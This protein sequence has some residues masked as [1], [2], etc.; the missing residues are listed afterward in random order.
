MCMTMLKPY[1]ISFSTVGIHTTL[2]QYA[3]TVHSVEYSSTNTDSPPDSNPGLNKYP[4]TNTTIHRR[5]IW[6][7]SRQCSVSKPKRHPAGRRR[8]S[9]LWPLEVTGT[10]PPRAWPAGTLLLNYDNYLTAQSVVRAPWPDHACSGIQAV[11]K[12]GHVNSISHA[13]T[14]GNRKRQP[15]LRFQ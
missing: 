4:R 9:H 12:L 11:V 6:V 7:T 8:G 1:S 13:W 5:A 14:C 3:P 15:P 2:R 10:R